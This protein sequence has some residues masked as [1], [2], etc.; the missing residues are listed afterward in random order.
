VCLIHHA[1]GSRRPGVPG[2]NEPM[3]SQTIIIVV[4]VVLLILILTGYIV[5]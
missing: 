5:V 3:P 1:I 2:N 4:V